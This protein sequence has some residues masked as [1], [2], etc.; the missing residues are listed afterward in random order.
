MPSF[1]P[2]LRLNGGQTPT[3]AEWRCWWRGTGSSG[4][5]WCASR[6]GYCEASGHHGAAS[7]GFASTPSRW[8]PQPPPCIQSNPAHLSSAPTFCDS[9][10]VES[11]A[12]G[13]KTS[14][15]PPLLCPLQPR[16]LACHWTWFWVSA[17][18]TGLD[19]A[20]AHSGM[21]RPAFA[22]GSHSVLSGGMWRP[23]NLTP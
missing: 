3:R 22:G 6:T 20:R 2:Q 1:P 19:H 16:V 13:E 11:H 4:G 18:C 5:A 14:S 9:Q 12:L 15:C 10:E 23:P 7:L 8:K 21:S 17:P